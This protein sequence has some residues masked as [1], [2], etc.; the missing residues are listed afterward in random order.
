M[1]FSLSSLDPSKGVKK[2]GNKFS[3]AGGFIDD[4][5]WQ[6]ASLALMAYTGY[7]AF[8]PGMAGTAAAEAAVANGTAASLTSAEAVAASTAATEAASLTGGQAA[9]LG[10]VG[11][12]TGAMAQGEIQEQVAERD[13]ERYNNDTTFF[14]INRNV[15]SEQAQA[16]RATNAVPGGQ[17]R[18]RSLAN[19]SASA[20]PRPQSLDDLINS[21]YA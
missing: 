4:N 11:S 21:Q 18:S 15:T 12:A 20:V 16:K 8:S 5:K 2:L 1:G 19:S 9:A 10:M 13:R 14:G 7:M 6:I 3:K 17:T